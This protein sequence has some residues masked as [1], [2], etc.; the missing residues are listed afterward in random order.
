MIIAVYIFLQ[1]HGLPMAPDR[2]HWTENIVLQ[3]R[4]TH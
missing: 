1:Q 4:Y 3:L 2:G